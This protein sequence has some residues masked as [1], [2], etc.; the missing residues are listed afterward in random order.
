MCVREPQMLPV[1]VAALLSDIGIGTSALEKVWRS[2]VFSP[3]LSVDDLREAG[4]H[5]RH[6]VAVRQSLRL[7]VRWCVPM[8][9]KRTGRKGEC[10]LVATLLCAA[11]RS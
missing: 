3:M 4:I 2:V 6:I 9:R 10:D 7:M 8:G 1:E 11:R 5:G